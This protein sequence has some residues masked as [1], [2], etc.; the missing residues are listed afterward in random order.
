MPTAA[1]ACAAIVVP[2][3]R[4]VAFI[5]HERTTNLTTLITHRVHHHMPELEEEEAA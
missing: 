1:V 3:T 5:P 2:G 4:V